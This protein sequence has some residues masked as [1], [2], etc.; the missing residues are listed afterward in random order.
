M[1]HSLKQLSYLIFVGVHSWAKLEAMIGGCG[2][3]RR[4]LKVWVRW[5]GNS[6]SAFSGKMLLA[7][8]GEISVRTMNKVGEFEHLSLSIYKT[9]PKQAIHILRL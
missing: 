3:E 1:Y 5:W 7:D 8:G 9:S 4:H 2:D 6:I